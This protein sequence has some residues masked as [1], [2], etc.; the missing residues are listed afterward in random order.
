[1]QFLPLTGRDG[2][3]NRFLYTLTFGDISQN[4]VELVAQTAAARLRLVA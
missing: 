1:V 4:G 2:K 3:K